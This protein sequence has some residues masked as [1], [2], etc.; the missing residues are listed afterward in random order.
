MLRMPMLKK[1]ATV[2]PTMQRRAFSMTSAS[3][4]ARVR[5]YNRPP[6]K[7]KAK[8]ALLT[9]PHTK[10]Y[11]LDDGASFFVRP[12]PTPIPPTIPIPFENTR[13]LPQAGPSATSEYSHPLLTRPPPSEQGDHA[14]NA[15]FRVRSTTPN[16]HLAPR[17]DRAKSADQGADRL[18]PAQI[19]ELRQ[20]RSSDPGRWTR[21]KLADKFGCS[22]SFVGIVG[23]SRDPKGESLRAMRRRQV[24]QERN[25]VEAMWSSRKKLAADERRARRAMW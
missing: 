20:L 13:E 21:K 8:D 7:P 15:P 2:A 11:S 25:N 24:E 4:H 14:E 1:S 3:L 9:S 12:P 10:V 19:L 16:A 17:L 18:T 5:D 22:E 23:F 6:R